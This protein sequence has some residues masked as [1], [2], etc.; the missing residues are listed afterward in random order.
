MFPLSILGG[1]WLRSPPLSPESHLPGL[2]YFLYMPRPRLHISIHSPGPLG[3]SP[4]PIPDPVS[5]FTFPS[6]LPPRSLSLSASHDYF[7]PP[8]NGIDASTLGPFY[9]LTLLIVC[10]LYFKYSVRFV[11]FVHC[12]YIHLSVGTYPACPFQA[13]LSHLG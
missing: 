11:H 10:G 12:A 13:G 1:F 9:L 5:L 7:L 8:S 2:W 3:F 6:P 4:T